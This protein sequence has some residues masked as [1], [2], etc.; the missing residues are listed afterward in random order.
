M[1]TGTV[2]FQVDHII[3]RNFRGKKRCM[4]RRDFYDHVIQPVE[5]PGKSICFPPDEKLLSQSSDLSF[6]CWKNR[7]SASNLK[8]PMK[9]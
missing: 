4:C 1:I 9:I 6:S 5:S 8:H 2:E 3:L 7:T